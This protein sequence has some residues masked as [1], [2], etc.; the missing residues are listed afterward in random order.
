[1]ET[2]GKFEEIWGGIVRVHM[3]GGRS[4]WAVI[5]A[6]LWVRCGRATVVFLP[7]IPSLGVTTAQVDRECSV[8]HRCPIGRLREDDVVGEKFPHYPWVSLYAACCD[9]S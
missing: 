5:G 4:G 9:C 7:G 1:L 3:L 6:V 8:I 2:S